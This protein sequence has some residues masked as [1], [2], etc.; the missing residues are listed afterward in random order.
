MRLND[1]IGSYEAARAAAVR[2]AA[3]LVL[4]NAV[5]ESIAAHQAL[6][7]MHD[8]DRLHLFHARFT[9]RDRLEIEDKVLKLFG[10][11]SSRAARPKSD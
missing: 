9:Q 2:G 1:R 11:D 8:A 7:V 10:R 4:C 3:V 5:D 6:S